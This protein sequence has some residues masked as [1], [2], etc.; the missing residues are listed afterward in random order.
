[1]PKN[2]T[3]ILS[4]VVTATSE[5]T[6][7][8][9]GAI[10]WHATE[11]DLALKLVG[12]N[13]VSEPLHTLGFALEYDLL[14]RGST[15]LLTGPF[16]QDPDT[17]RAL[18]KH[19]P[20]TES[21]LSNH[22]PDP[23]EL[24]GKA[25]ISGVGKVLEAVMDNITNAGGEWNLTVQAEHEYYDPE[26][27]RKLDFVI[28]YRFGH[29]TPDLPELDEIQVGSLMWLQGNIVNKDKHSK[30]FIVQV[31]HHYVIRTDEQK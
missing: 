20:L 10:A 22:T 5:A 21:K 13:V 12:E 2:L 23:K 28:T 11:S 8:F 24:A 6:R 27:Q 16:G 26:T 17:G 25:S 31:L 1:M 19:S 30:R 9:P 14:N 29:F 18:M 3:T 7:L 4:A 15:Y